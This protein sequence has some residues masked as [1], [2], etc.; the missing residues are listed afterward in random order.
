VQLAKGAQL[1]A[2]NRMG[3]RPAVLGPANV[4]SGRAIKF[5][6]GPFQVTGLDGAKPMPIG[7]EDQSRVTV[8]VAALAGG[9]DKRFDFRWRQILTQPQFVIGGAPRNPSLYAN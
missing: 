9:P 1:V 5:D 8:P 3:R 6:L 7:H 2:P 4:Q